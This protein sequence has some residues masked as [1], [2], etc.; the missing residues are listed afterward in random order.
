MYFFRRPS[1]SS[2][3][4]RGQ[5]YDIVIN[6]ASIQKIKFAILKIHSF[7]KLLDDRDED[8]DEEDSVL[9]NNAT[10][11][12]PSGYDSVMAD[13]V[14]ID[15][16]LFLFHRGR[17]FLALLVGSG[18]CH[19]TKTQPLFNNNSNSNERLISGCAFFSL[20][21]GPHPETLTPIGYCVIGPH[22]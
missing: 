19:G 1:L 5:R 13:C 12:I 18:L 2:F 3:A 16:P 6:V 22:A 9:I 20:V 4:S 10:M 21:T 15:K 17:L 14:G 7:F 11:K 8:E